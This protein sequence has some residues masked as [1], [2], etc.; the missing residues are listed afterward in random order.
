M[1]KNT[2]KT[3]RSVKQAPAQMQSPDNASLAE[4]ETDENLEK[5]AEK[6][7]KEWNKPVKAGK[8]PDLSF[9]KFAEKLRK[10]R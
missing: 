8:K 5:M 4:K 2:P 7:T 6:L 3:D 1:K 9:A 10:N